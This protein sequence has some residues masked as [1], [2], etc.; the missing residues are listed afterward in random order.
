MLTQMISTVSSDMTRYNLEKFQRGREGGECK[1]GTKKIYGG[2]HTNMRRLLSL[3]KVPR[4]RGKNSKKEELMPRP[5]NEYLTFI[6]V[7]YL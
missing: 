2:N 4:G 6:C 3:F 1:N 5:L 7:L